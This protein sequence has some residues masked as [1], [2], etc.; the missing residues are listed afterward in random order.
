MSD[1]DILFDIEGSSVSLAD[2]AGLDMDNITEN[3]GFTFPKGMVDLKVVSA[4]LDQIGTDKKWPCVQF[5]AEVLNFPGE[6]HDAEGKQIDPSHL[7]GSIY[8][9]T[10]IIG[11]ADDLG[12]VK[13][14]MSDSGHKGT[15]AFGDNLG[16][17]AG[18]TFR[19]KIRHKK[20]KNDEEQI[21][22][23]IMRSKVKALNAE[24]QVAA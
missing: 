4:A 21:N 23:R 20:N 6:V 13:A 12:S 9:E 15:G 3:R 24:G 11:S 7:V 14:M 8:K 10:F 22:A 17:W 1:E 19:T 5:E 16:N 18:C 2:I